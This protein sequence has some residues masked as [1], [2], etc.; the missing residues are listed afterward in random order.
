MKSIPRFLLAAVFLALAAT[1]RSVTAAETIVR[2]SDYSRTI[3]VECVGDSI[4]YGRGIKDHDHDTYPAR[5]GQMLGRKWE[6]RNFGENGATVLVAGTHPYVAVQAYHDA[7]DF[8]PDVVILM[9]GTNDS[10]PRS[11]GPFQKE[12]EGDYR[13]LVQVFAA[14]DSKP[15]IF[16]CL[17]PPYGRKRADDVGR[18]EILTGKIGPIIQ[19]VARDHGFIVI[20][21]HTLFVGRLDLFPDA[22][23]PGEEA[24]RIM[25][26]VVFKVI[27][28]GREPRASR[29]SFRPCDRSNLGRRLSHG[30][31]QPIGDALASAM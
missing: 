13:R 18:P 27:T 9:L 17:P 6:V 2:E 28:G 29:Q 10:G 4:T 15:R 19:Q 5:L 22:V 23:H 12:F 11:W 14:L 26:E 24:A 8:K 31:I 3:R 21:L 7:L 20:D 25:A 30:L 1:S 16:L